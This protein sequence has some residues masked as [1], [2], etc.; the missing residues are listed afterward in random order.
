MVILLF[1]EHSSLVHSDSRLIV[2]Q[3]ND[4]FEVEEE[5][6]KHYLEEVKQ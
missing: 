6:I 3:V 4:K 5:K 1:F 2:N